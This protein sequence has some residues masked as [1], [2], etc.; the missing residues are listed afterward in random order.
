MFIEQDSI[1]SCLQSLLL[2]SFK[3]AIKVVQG[4]I[5]HIINLSLSLSSH[6]HLK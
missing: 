4:E 3:Q 1:S 6:K 2:P 5:I